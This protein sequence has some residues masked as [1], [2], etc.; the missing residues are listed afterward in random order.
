MIGA[1]QWIILTW[2]EINQMKAVKKPVQLGVGNRLDP[3]G[4]GRIQLFDTVAQPVF[5]E[6]IIGVQKGNEAP[7]GVRQNGIAHAAQIP[8]AA[9]HPRPVIEP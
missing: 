2:L 4:L 7:L 1:E 6:Q 3:V 8:L 9:R 5:R